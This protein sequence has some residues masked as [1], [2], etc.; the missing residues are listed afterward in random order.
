[1]EHGIPVV[2]LWLQP[3]EIAPE[4]VGEFT[5]PG[6]E[7]HALRVGVGSRDQS[8]VGPRHQRSQRRIGCGRSATTRADIER[9]ASDA[10][11]S[12]KAHGVDRRFGDADA[13]GDG[14]AEPEQHL[15]AT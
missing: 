1:M 4:F 14:A 3:L 13:W 11:D 8:C 15:A 5:Q 7:G 6:H 9:I 10:F 12:G 2:G